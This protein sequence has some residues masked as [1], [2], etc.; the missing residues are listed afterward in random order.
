M[1]H[2]IQTVD[3]TGDC[4]KIQ[5]TSRPILIKF[6]HASDVGE[7]VAAAVQAEVSVEVDGVWTKIGGTL[8]ANKEWDSNSLEPS[9]EFDI[10]PMLASRIEDAAFPI[11]D[12]T[13]NTSVSTSHLN[14]VSQTDSK[15]MIRYKVEARALY[16]DSDTGILTLNESDDALAHPTPSDYRY[17][18]GAF[19]PDSIVTSDNYSNLN[20]NKGW[21]ISDLEGGTIPSSA[22][23]FLTNCPPSLRR[24]IFVAQP[25]AL[26]ALNHDWSGATVTVA[27]NHSNDVGSPVANDEVNSSFLSSGVD[28]LKSINIT[29]TDPFLF[30]TLTGSTVAACGKDF[31]LFTRT[32]TVNGVSLN[33][34]LI[35]SET[36]SNPN[37]SKI[38][39]NDTVIYFIND[40]G[41]WDYYIFDG[42]L[43]ITHTHEKSTFKKGVKDY[44]SRQSSRTG[45]SRG[46]TTEL[47]T[48]HTLVNKEASMW[49]SEIFRSRTVYYYDRS[50]AAFVPITVVDGET[51]PLSSNK[52]SLEPFSISFIK[53]TYTI[54]G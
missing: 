5:T 40:F 21:N 51:Y 33:F 45:V 36:T 6:E 26:Y 34:E 28:D 27:A 25:M 17:A 39:S 20:V 7:P 24:R 19:L 8:V 18:I 14:T 48:C 15:R 22:F 43:D 37:L 30:G 29:P 12:F 41:V 52:L 23:Q 53:D 10:S 42:F 31:S 13:T 4:E 3:I 11:N 44:T 9:F 47:Y 49:L 35:N 32:N 38:K 46:T 50:E 1:S 2:N 16:V 54:K